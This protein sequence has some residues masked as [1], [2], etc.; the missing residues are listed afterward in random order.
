MIDWLSTVAFVFENFSLGDDDSLCF[1]FVNDSHRRCW[2]S[3]AAM[4]PRRRVSKF[5]RSCCVHWQRTSVPPLA[6]SP[7][8]HVC[9]SLSLSSARAT[10]GAETRS[11]E[12]MCTCV[13]QVC[14]CGCVCAC[15]GR[16]VVHGVRVQE[17]VVQDTL[18]GSLTLTVV[19]HT[20]HPLLAPVDRISS[21]FCYRCCLCVLGSAGAVS[22]GGASKGGGGEDENNSAKKKK[23]QKTCFFCVEQKK[24]KKKTL[25]QIRR[26][27]F[28][29]K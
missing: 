29:E 27:I 18:D 16:Y 12:C 13:L 7:R 14:V 3:S 15:S 17:Q 22:R 8:H 23:K 2:R 21:L 25:F 19:T 5:R 6:S 28:C 11:K 10:W 1:L 26:I 24:K 9:L 4:W 20:S